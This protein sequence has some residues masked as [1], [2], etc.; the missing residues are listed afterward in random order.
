MTKKPVV[1]GICIIAAVVVAWFFAFGPLN[2]SGRNNLRRIPDYE[3]Q[4][5]MG[6]LP[7]EGD[8][9]GFDEEPTEEAVPDIE[10]PKGE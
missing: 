9:R 1:A 8:F 10:R 5:K 6:D 3:S 2:Y 4:Q 7:D